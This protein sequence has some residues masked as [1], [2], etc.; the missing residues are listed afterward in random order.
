MIAIV[1]AA[2]KGS[3]MRKKSQKVLTPFLGYPM[4]KYI[5]DALIAC[6]IKK[7]YVVIGYYGNRVKKAL[8]GYDVV[9]IEQKKRLG[10]AHAVYQAKKFLQN[11]ESDL[12][13]VPGDFPLLGVRNINNLIRTHR[14]H[15]ASL[16][17][18]TAKERKSD[19]GS[20]VR[21][22]KN[23]IIDLVVVDREKS[24]NREVSAGVYLFKS[25]KFLYTELEKIC[26]QPQSENRLSDIVRNY[27]QN[28]KR[29]RNYQMENK[30]CCTHGVNTLEQLTSMELTVRNYLLENSSNRTI[31]SHKKEIKVI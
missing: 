20:V 19:A 15:R 2:G 28:R 7:I 5:I 18:L 29:I 22:Y 16:T 9:F 1:L 6:D 12:L 17:L 24:A 8:K 30:F 31:H 23:R 25:A 3:R 14:K 10:T 4:I 26:R 11:H 13:I 27:Y 21:G